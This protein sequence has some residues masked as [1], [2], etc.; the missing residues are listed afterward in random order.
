[1]TNYNWFNTP[2]KSQSLF[3]WVLSLSHLLLFATP[4][5]AAHQAS[6][7]ITNSWSL[8]KL[9]SIESMMPFIH[10]ILCCRLLLLHS[11][12]PNIRVF[13]MSQFFVSGG[14]SI[15]ASASVSVLPMNT[16]TD[17]LYNG[18][19]DLLAV[20]GTLKSSP[21]PQFKRISSSGLSCLYSQNLTSIHD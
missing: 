7:S 3:N 6:L 16:Q 12:F 13:L 4:W 9:T 19:L 21:S 15:G 1:M 5:T 14:Q 17:F 18:L 2:I 20:R 11:I 10:I 8:L